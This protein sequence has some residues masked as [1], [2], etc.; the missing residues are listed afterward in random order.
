M[1]TRE[2][3]VRGAFELTPTV[4]GDTRG[5]FHEWFRADA[6]PAWA[7][8]PFG[9]AQANCSVSAAGTLRGIHFAEVPPGQGK[10]VTCIKG[11]VLDVAVDLFADSPGFGEWDSV[12]LDDVD[13]RC[14]Y[15][16]AGLGHGFVALEDS[17]VAY[18]CDQPYSP[19]TE[20]TVNPLD[21][22][23][24]IDWSDPRGQAT[25]LQFILSDRDRAAPMLAEVRAA[26]V[27]PSH[28]GA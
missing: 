24:G 6:L 25:D 8:R 17:V 27:L 12:L 28:G 7:E 26:G 19:S 16:P 2:L 18:L 3:D 23:L 11:A 21:P 15:L 14:I 10:Y 5:S 1:R 4:Y 22:A 20:H 13:R 9:L